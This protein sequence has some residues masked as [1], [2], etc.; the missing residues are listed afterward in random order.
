M[1]VQQEIILAHIQEQLRKEKDKSSSSTTG[2][3][4]NVTDDDEST[5]ADEGR[6]LLRKRSTFGDSSDADNDDDEDDEKS[7]DQQQQR[8]DEQISF[9]KVLSSSITMPSLFAPKEDD[10]DEAEKLARAKRIEEIMRLSAEI[11]AKEAEKE[12]VANI[13]PLSWA[14]PTFDLPSTTNTLGKRKVQQEESSKNSPD[15]AVRS[16]YT[17]PS[18][19]GVMKAS[20][21][22]S[23]KLSPSIKRRGVEQ[24][25]VDKPDC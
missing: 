8:E 4:K 5:I 18:G 24:T 19:E 25:G 21:D 6:A 12:R 17:R 16:S 1:N 23:D 10:C 20:V 9:C 14:K 22:F 3:A 15:I 2:S 7:S 11:K 13:R